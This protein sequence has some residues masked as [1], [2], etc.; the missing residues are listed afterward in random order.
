MCLDSSTQSDV[1]EA[2]TRILSNVFEDIARETW[3]YNALAATVLTGLENTVK[4]ETPM[5]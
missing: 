5:G 3:Y 2:A 1:L 4:V